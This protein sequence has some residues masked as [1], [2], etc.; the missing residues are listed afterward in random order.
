M[1]KKLYTSEIID[2]ITHLTPFNSCLIREDFNIYHN[3]FKPDITNI[4]KKGE[5]TAL[6]NISNINYI[7]NPEEVTYNTSYILDLSFLNIPFVIISIQTNIYYTLDYKVQVT[8]I[9]SKR[10]VLLK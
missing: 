2:Y 6:F 5:L 4:N 9:L 8:V 7:K 3:M 1:Y 10:K